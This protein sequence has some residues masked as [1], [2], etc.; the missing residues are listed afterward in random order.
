MSAYPCCAGTLLLTLWG[1]LVALRATTT[2][3]RTINT[4]WSTVVLR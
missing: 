1:G 4:A 2:T 3:K